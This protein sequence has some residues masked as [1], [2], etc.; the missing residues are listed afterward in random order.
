[1]TRSVWQRPVPVSITTNATLLDAK[2]TEWL[3]ATGWQVRVSLDGP[4][5]TH[6]RWRV[7]RS[8]RGT[9]D[10]VSSR[11]RRLAELLGDRLVVNAV[12]CQGTD[13]TSVQQAMAEL[14][15]RK[16][17][18]LPVASND[19]NIRLGPADLERYAEFVSDHA[20]QCVAGS[21]SRPTLL[22]F[23]EYVR[24]VMGWH[25]GSVVC[26][27]ARSYVA[28]GPAGALYPCM[29]FIG[30]EHYRLGRLPEGLEPEAVLAFQEGPGRPY[31]ERDSCRDCWAAPMCCGPCFACA[32]MFD[33]EPNCQFYK[34]EARAAVWLVQE[35]RQRDLERL[36]EFL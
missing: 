15:V 21:P 8:G 4:R 31:S 36:V 6:D 24:R 34:A 12:F 11:V 22:R 2:T 23:S 35:L 27:A 14:G 5:P 28:V 32:E 33:I 30:I 7:T 20:R 1:L 26:D 25:N 29:R 18:V 13:P 19:P 17:Y 9:F 10:L 3:A 16:L